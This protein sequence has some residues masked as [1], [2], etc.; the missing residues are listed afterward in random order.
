M[1]QA[2]WTGRRRVG[3]RQGRLGRDGAPPR[4][5]GR[6]PDVSAGGIGPYHARFPDAPRNRS[7]GPSNGKGL[8]DRRGVE[9]CKDATHRAGVS[10]PLRDRKSFG[11]RRQA[12]PAQRQSEVRQRP[13]S[14][15]DVRSAVGRSFGRASHVAHATQVLL[16][17][18]DVLCH[19]EAAYPCPC[20]A[21]GIRQSR[22]GAI[23]CSTSTKFG[24]EIRTG[25]RRTIRLSRAMRRPRCTT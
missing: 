1:G 5:S 7:C 3:N 20:R 12:I 16:D 11:H 8:S 4:R 21:A 25:S 6:R 13:R 18:A 9:N 22:I 15:A 17:D 24:P 10:D 2:S 14:S 19:R 23:G